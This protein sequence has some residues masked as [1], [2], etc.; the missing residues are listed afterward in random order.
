MLILLE[1]DKKKNQTMLEAFIMAFVE[2]FL[3]IPPSKTLFFL[4]YGENIWYLVL[5]LTEELIFSENI[6]QKVVQFS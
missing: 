5:L 1:L 3:G 4:G 2:V 6:R